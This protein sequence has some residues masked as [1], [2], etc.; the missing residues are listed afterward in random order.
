[1]A[2][3]INSPLRV[4]RNSSDTTMRCAERIAVAA[5]DSRIAGVAEALKASSQLT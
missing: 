5:V 2:H 3:E 4:I 1:V